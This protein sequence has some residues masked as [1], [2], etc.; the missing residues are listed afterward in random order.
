MRYPVGNTGTREEFERDWYVAQGFG[1]QTSYGF[2]EGA[3]IN[4]KT[5]GDTDLGQELKSIAN[6]RI[7]YYHNAS[8]PTSGFGRHLVVRIEGPWG[9]RWVHYA[10]CDLQDFHGAVQ[11]VTEGQIIARLG[12]SGTSAAHLH[13]SIRK[14]DP[15]NEG[16]DDIANTRT[17]L[18]TDWEDPIAFI[19]T[20]IV[21]PAPEPIPDIRLAL[22]DVAGITTESLTRTAI[23]RYNGWDELQASKDRLQVERDILISRIETVKSILG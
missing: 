14:T 4:L 20:W 5:G 1:V 13:F 9:V 2:H 8:H 11:D 12:K 21:A 17:E 22:L 6:G 19:N 3:D 23:D 7:V 10:H 18:D 16:I 15:A